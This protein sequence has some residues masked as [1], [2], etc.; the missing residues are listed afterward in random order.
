[1]QKGGTI[2]SYRELDNIRTN[3]LGIHQVSSATAGADDTALL[4][5]T[6]DNHAYVDFTKNVIERY[7]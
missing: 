1:M 5:P 6:Y 3:R 4:C 2:R 7:S